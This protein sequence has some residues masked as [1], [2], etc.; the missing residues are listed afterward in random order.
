MP[1]SQKNI[2]PNALGLSGFGRKNVVR[3]SPRNRD[4]VNLGIKWKV[5]NTWTIKRL[6]NLRQDVPTNIDKDFLILVVCTCKL[7]MEIL[8]R[9]LATFNVP[10]F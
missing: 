7:N 5:V 1:I 4:K 6:Q 2:T 10:R 3:L 8:H 9:F